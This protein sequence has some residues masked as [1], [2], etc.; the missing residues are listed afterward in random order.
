M[1]PPGAQLGQD[2]SNI[3]TQRCQ[4]GCVSVAGPLG[5]ICDAGRGTSASLARHDVRHKRGGRIQHSGYFTRLLD[6][7]VPTMLFWRGLYAGLFMSACIVLMRGR[8]TVASVS[9]IGLA[10]LLVALLSAAATVCYVSALRLTTVAEVMA[11]NATS[12]FIAGVLAW[13]IIGETERWPV[14][15]AS[16]FALAGVVIMVGLDAMTGHFAGA[17]LA[18]MQMFFL[19]L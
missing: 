3:L 13:L 1:H 12:P 7:D 6:L 10:G 8:K 9:N 18:F 11:I 4:E 14:I 15:L 5:G 19:A 2:W 16:L 17:V